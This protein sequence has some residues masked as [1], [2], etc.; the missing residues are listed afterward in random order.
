MIF[1]LTG[2]GAFNGPV[3]RIVDARGYFVGEKPALVLEK[4]DG[5]HADVL[6]RFEK[7]AGGIF[8]GA[9]DG[10]FKAGGGS[11]GKAQ[12]AAA[13]VVFDERIKSDFARA[14]AN[15]ENRKL[16]SERHEAFE[17]ETNGRQLRFGPCD[18]LRSAENPLAF[19]VV[20]HA[21]S[22][23]N[24]GET[25]MLESGTEFGVFRNGC[26][27]G[28]GDAKF[29]EEVLFAQA[30]LRGFEGEGRRI[31]R[32][33]LSEKFHGFNGD[34]FEFISDE[35]EAAREFFERGV[36]GVLGGDALGDA[37]YGSFRRRVEK[38]EVQAERIARESEHVAEL[39]PAKDANGHARLPFLFGE[40]TADGSGWESTRP[41]CSARNFRS[42][43]RKE[44]CFVARMAAARSAALT[45]PDLPM[46]SVPTGMPLGICAMERSESSPLRAFD[47]TG[48]P[49][50]GRTVFDAVMPGR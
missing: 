48:T 4:F 3:T 29:L 8:R 39:P 21:R 44:G 1:E 23:Q 2:D 46:A 41:V 30:V 32:D 36:I 31:D 45:A 43:S 10:G 49:R 5:K 7:T 13:M 34:V 33:A 42:A 26:E 14:R 27:F 40:E 9:L 47:S 22:L 24:G 12:N 25:N 17:D 35:L 18:I 20:A 37:A 38:A 28:R 16:A 50:T 19:A 11:E 15:R 6:Q